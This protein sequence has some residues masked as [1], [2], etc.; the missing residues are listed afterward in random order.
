MTYV[1]IEATLKALIDASS[2]TTGVQGV[3]KTTF[4]FAKENTPVLVLSH[5]DVVDTAVKLVIYPSNSA[6]L[7]Q[8]L[9]SEVWQYIGDVKIYAFKELD[10]VKAFT[11]LK[12][13]GDA[14]QDLLFFF[15]GPSGDPISAYFWGVVIFRWNQHISH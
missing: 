4:V 2:W 3:T 13:I 15:P 14:V 9:G 8:T 5:P 11:A 12:V 7:N 6:P 1:D 10:L